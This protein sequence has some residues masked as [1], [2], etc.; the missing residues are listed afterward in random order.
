MKWSDLKGTS[1]VN[2][3][4]AEKLG[5]IEDML[6]DG[7]GKRVLG[8]RVRSGGGLRTHHEAMLLSD[9]KSFGDDAVTIDDQSRLN[10]EDTFSDLRD[11]LTA[12]GIVGSK[13]M[14]EDGQQIGSI[15]D[16]SADMD[17]ARVTDYQMG[18]GLLDRLRGQDHIIPVDAVRSIGDGLVVITNADA[19]TPRN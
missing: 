5:S 9:V 19:V 6:L 10:R 3:G 14:T 2:V 16:L 15:S 18:A 8:F 7:A 12:S 11:S 1:V 4:T 13:V 17:A